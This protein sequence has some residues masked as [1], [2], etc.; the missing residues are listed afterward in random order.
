MG[1]G[2]AAMQRPLLKLLILI[3][4]FPCAAA[5]AD[6]PVQCDVHLLVHLTPDVPD[7]AAA[8]FLSSLLTNPNFRLA[9][10]GKSGDRDVAMEL[11]GPGSAAACAQVIDGMR[12]DA[13]IVSIEI[14]GGTS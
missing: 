10:L 13:R 7:L 6:T 3:A 11:S 2:E 4:M 1:Y 9:V 8:G 12:R 14:Q 5:W